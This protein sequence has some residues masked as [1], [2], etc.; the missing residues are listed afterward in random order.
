MGRL[1]VEMQD[2]LEEALLGL[3]FEGNTSDNRG[4]EECRNW[5]TPSLFPT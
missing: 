4:T 1:D 5:N 2:D 3:D